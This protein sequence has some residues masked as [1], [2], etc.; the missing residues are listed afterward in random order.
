MYPFGYGLSYSEVTYSDL[1]LSQ[2]TLTEFTE[3]E[4]TVQVTNHDPKRACQE[5][6]QLYIQDEVGSVVRPVRELK[7][8]EKVE[9]AAGETRQVSFTITK[10][11]LKYFTK[12]LSFDVEPGWFKV[13]VGANA[14]A[15]LEAR[16]ELV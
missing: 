4:V 16:F 7:A 9:L 1:T 15:T 6:I 5:V 2:A 14:A 13:F 12:D 3:L 10:K 8:F 11:Q